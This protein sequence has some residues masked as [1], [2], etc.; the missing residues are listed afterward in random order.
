MKVLILVAFLAL[1]LNELSEALEVQCNFTIDATTQEYSCEAKI[2]VTGDLRLID[3]MIGWHLPGRVNG[4][5][6][7]FNIRKQKGFKKFPRGLFKFFAKIA[8]I[9]VQET[10]IDEITSDDLEGLP[11]V[12]DVDLSDNEITDLPNDLF[13]NCPLLGNLKISGNPIIN[14]GIDLIKNLEKL[15]TIDVSKDPCKKAESGS[16]EDNLLK[17]VLKLVLKKNEEESC[18]Q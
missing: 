4:H 15:E 6:K 7:G 16:G 13:K 5:V 10:E 12:V 8:K 11:D 2:I 3:R 14:I 18:S 17:S 9:I 1:G